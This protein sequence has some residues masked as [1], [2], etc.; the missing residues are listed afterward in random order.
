MFHCHKRNRTHHRRHR[1]TIIKTAFPLLQLLKIRQSI[2]DLVSMRNEKLVILQPRQSNLSLS[3][4]KDFKPQ[5]TKCIVN[6][7]L[8]AAFNAI[9]KN[10]FGAAWIAVLVKLRFPRISYPMTISK[11]SHSP[12]HRTHLTSKA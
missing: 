7:G 9:N 12:T 5:P 10:G 3:K 4:K 11:K 6:L 1:S 8:S 2:F